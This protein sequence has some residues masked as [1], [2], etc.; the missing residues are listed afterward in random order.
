[1]STRT[2]ILEFLFILLRASPVNNCIESRVS[3]LLPI[4]HAASFP[5]ILTFI[6]FPSLVISNLHLF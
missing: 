2:L 4:K 5:V 3:P 1:M 6:T